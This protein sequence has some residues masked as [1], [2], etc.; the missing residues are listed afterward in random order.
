[1]VQE[2]K[3]LELTATVPAEM[4]A[5]QTQ[6][7][8]WCDKKILAAQA[9]S[10]ELGEEVEHAKKNK[11]KAGTLQTQHNRS[12]RRVQYYEKIKAA[13]E[14]GYYIVPNFPIEMFAI[15]KQHGRKPRGWS[16]N[17]WASHQQEAA[18]LPAGAGDYKNPFPLVIRESEELPNGTFKSSSYPTEWDDFEFPINMAKPKIMSITQTALAMKVFDRVGV[19]PSVRRRKED[20]VIIGQIVHKQGGLSE[21]VISFMIAWHLNTN[22]I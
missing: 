11:W 8:A 9:E 2:V 10:Q 17:K 18:E 20:P 3:D 14:A 13:L 6:L 15:R 12:I 16:N 22:V 21:K 1:M 19:M 5:S 4:V 7:I